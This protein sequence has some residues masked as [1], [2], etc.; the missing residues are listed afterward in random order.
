MIEDEILSGQS[1]SVRPSVVMP[2]P[3]SG[4]GGMATRLNET[5]NILSLAGFDVI[6]FCLKR[7]ESNEWVDSHHK[8]FGSDATVEDFANWINE[9][10]PLALLSFNSKLA[11]GAYALIDESIIKIS[12]LN[13][14]HYSG[15]YNSFFGVEYSDFMLYETQ[16]MHKQWCKI[17]EGLGVDLFQIPQYVKDTSKDIY[18]KKEKSNAINLVYV[19][20]LEEKNKN[21]SFLLR[22]VDSLSSRRIEFILNIV[23]DGPD[24]SL[25]KSLEN[26]ANVI[27]HGYLNE[28][29]RDLVLAKQDILIFPS[30]SEGFG[31]SLIEAC[32]FCV[33]PLINRL[34]H[35]EEMLDGNC[36]ELSVSNAGQWA[37]VIGFLSENPETLTKYQIAAR[38]YCRGKYSDNS[39]LI[40]AFKLLFFDGDAR[41][42]KRKRNSV[43][44]LVV[45]FVNSFPDAIRWR[46]LKGLYRF[47]NKA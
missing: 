16:I 17:C 43:F 13:S 40:N 32:Y 34:P 10:S 12:V 25:L 29:D 3:V 46:I 24:K 30:V 31:I 11:Q 18:I 8:I 19:G 38:N 14:V 42:V 41:R 9:L 6:T 39:V 47:V 15:F 2:V 7:T 23:G 28:H 20:R 35:I 4:F 22:L 36:I 27:F 21:I 33:F 44:W 1:I 26:H 45:V 5:R 37:E